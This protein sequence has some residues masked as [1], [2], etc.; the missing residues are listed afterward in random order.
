MSI[1][2]EV[3][4][5]AR[6]LCRERRGWTFSPA[7][8]VRALPHINARSVRTHVVSRCCVNAPKNHPHRLDYFRRVG[9]GLYELLPRYRKPNPTLDTHIAEHAAVY[10][11]EPGNIRDV[12]HAVCHRD[13]SFFVA[14][15]AE[16]AVVTQGRSLDE[17]VTN[18]RDAVS[19]HLEGGDAATLGISARPRIVLTYEIASGR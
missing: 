3:L 16:I 1:Q 19:L 14:E 9:R 15:C 2:Q 4:A 5:A 8:L 18:L 6:A 17:L 13:R 11:T 7:D 10:D 12:V